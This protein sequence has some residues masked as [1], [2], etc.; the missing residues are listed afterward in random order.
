MTVTTSQITFNQ[1]NMF[2]NLYKHVIF[3][4]THLT[5][6]FVQGQNKWRRLEMDL[7]TYLCVRTLLS[8][9]YLMSHERAWPIFRQ[10]LLQISY[11]VVEEY[12]N[13]NWTKPSHYLAILTD[14]HCHGD[15]AIKLAGPTVRIFHSR[16]FIKFH[17]A[18]LQAL[19]NQQEYKESELVTQKQIPQKK[20]CFLEQY[21]C[22]GMLT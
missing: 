16:C 17:L 13:P 3:S 9:E 12:L 10:M 22:Q 21:L 19:S 7:L 4:E 14:E 2:L 8:A 11:A 6:C 5:L 15:E 1:H 20:K 18:H